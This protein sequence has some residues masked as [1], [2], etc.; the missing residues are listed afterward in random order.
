MKSIA[1]VFSVAAT[2]LLLSILL[3]N[4]NALVVSRFTQSSS[5][6]NS[7]DSRRAF[8]STAAAGIASAIVGA[9]PALALEDMAMPSTEEQKQL[10]DVRTF[11][12]P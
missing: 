3:G 5:A 11:L 10:D 7:I 12:L 8:L 4:A 9:A 6:L 2:A 1:C